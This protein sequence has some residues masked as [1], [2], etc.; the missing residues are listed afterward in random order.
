MRNPLYKGGQENT[1]GE[2]GA[3]KEAKESEPPSYS[4]NL[5]VP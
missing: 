5:G 2:K 1:I 3:Q 4:H